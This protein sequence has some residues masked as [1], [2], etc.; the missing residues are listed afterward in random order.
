MSAIT[1]PLSYPPSDSLTGFKIDTKGKLLLSNTSNANQR[2]LKYTEFVWPYF[3]LG[4]LKHYYF[5]PTKIEVN[6]GSYDIELNRKLEAVNC[7]DM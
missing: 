3:K 4:T 2:T 7:Y 1:S 5:A 6:V